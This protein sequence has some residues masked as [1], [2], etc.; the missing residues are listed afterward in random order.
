MSPKPPARAFDPRHL[1]LLR[2]ADSASTL[3]GTQP[4]AELLRLSADARG[5]AAVHWSA[6]GEQRP[7]AGAAPETWLHV[8]ARTRVSLVCQRCLQPLDE[9]LQAE[10]SFRFVGDEAEAER[11]DE[12]SEDDVLALPPRGLLDLTAL[13]EDELILA[14]PIVPRH[15]MCP[16]PLT[17]LADNLPDD[18]PPNPFQ[19]LAVLKRKP[20]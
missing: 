7:V 12:E 2:F 5:T 6:R 9:A 10:R 8:Q 13:V 3:E 17:V 20:N 19:A 11:L 14:L 18:T 4:V 16:E 1:N 15:L